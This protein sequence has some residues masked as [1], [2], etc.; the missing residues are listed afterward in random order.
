MMIAILKRHI[1]QYEAEMKRI[2][3]DIEVYRANGDSFEALIQARVLAMV[4]RDAL[5]KVLSEVQK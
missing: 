4:Q 5:K 2:E 1:E 3:Q